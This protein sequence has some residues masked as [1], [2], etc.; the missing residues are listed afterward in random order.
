MKKVVFILF[1]VFAALS[2]FTEYKY[3]KK[4]E[5]QIAEIEKT[6]SE[7]KA[8]IERMDK[9]I[10]ALEIEIYNLQFDVNEIVYSIASE[11]TGCPVWILR[12]L[13]F[14]E[15]SYGA[16]CNHVDPFDTGEYGLNERPDRRSERVKKWG[17]YD[18]TNKLDSVIIAGHIIME[19]YEIMGD[20]NK[21]ISAYRRG[22]T[23]TNRNGIDWQ[24]VEKVKE[25]GNYIAS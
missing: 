3:L 9:Q 12:G 5:S 16:N 8:E 10:A 1:L 13:Q 6:L 25:G 19:N 11:K 15:S 4:Q 17:E 14:A 21:A 2:I 7:N 20:M 18:A 24:Y 23:G 22:R